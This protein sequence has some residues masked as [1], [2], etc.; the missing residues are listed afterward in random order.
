MPT[1]MNPTME[2]IA[3]AHPDIIAELR[4]L[5]PLKTAAS[6]AGF[7]AMPELQANCFRIEALVH[8][9]A[10]YCEGRTAPTNGF[11]RRSFERLGNGYCGAMEDPSEDVFVTLVNTS[12]GNFRIFEG[13]REATGFYLQRILNIVERMPEHT[14]YNRIRSSIECLLKLSDAVAARACVRENS[15]GQE[16]PLATLAKG[17]ADRSSLARGLVR[18]SEDDLASLEI[19]K[20]SLSEFIF[21][22]DDRFKLR[23]HLMG[24]TDLERRPVALHRQSA[25]LLLPTAVASAVTRFVIESVLS[26]G[27]AE[28]FERALSGEFAQLFDHTPILGGNLGVRRR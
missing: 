16:F 20:T 9:A 19:P 15:L 28:T 24:H 1:V 2:R 25:Y 6:F 27:L 21:S 22:S 7:L 3:E 5:D 11:I 23:G 26:M 8:L 17:V 12:R 4:K 10:A 13:I 18:F 14:P